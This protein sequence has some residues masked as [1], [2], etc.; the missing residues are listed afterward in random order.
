MTENLTGLLKIVGITVL[1]LLLWALLSWYVPERF[2]GANNIENLM[3]R[4]ALY[5]V[6]GIGV[7]FVIIS[8]GSIFR[9][10]R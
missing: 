1:L 10:D 5:G 8:G 6:L 4:T 9:L 7:A 3:R 2:L